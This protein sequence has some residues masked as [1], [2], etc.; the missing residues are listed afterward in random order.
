MKY[1]QHLCRLE[2]HTISGTDSSS[3]HIATGVASPSAQG[4]LIT[5]T[6]IAIDKENSKLWPVASHT[7]IDTKAIAITTGTK[8]PLILSANLAIG[9]FEEPASSTSLMICESAVSSPTLTFDTNIAGLIDCCCRYTIA[10]LL[11]YRHTFS[12]QRRHINR[13][14]T[15]YNYAINRIDEPGLTTTISPLRTSSAG[16]STSLPS[17]SMKAF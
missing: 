10:H 4:Q 13:G 7:I 6:A 14:L 3:N 11:V 2:Q 17:L 16:I 9:A 8:M 12:C 5:R 1:F 15:L